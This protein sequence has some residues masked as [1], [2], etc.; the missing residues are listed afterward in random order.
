MNPNEETLLVENDASELDTVQI[1]NDG[2]NRRH[3]VNDFG[4]SKELQNEP[5]TQFTLSGTEELITLRNYSYQDDSD[6]GLM[7]EMKKDTNR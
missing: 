1:M 6:E 5:R 7:D 4:M 3:E 2:W